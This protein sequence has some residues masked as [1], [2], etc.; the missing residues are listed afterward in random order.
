MNS[1]LKLSYSLLIGAFVAGVVG[2]LFH[3]Y[4]ITFAIILLS[5][6]FLLPKSLS[7]LFRLIAAYGI[8]FVANALIV[9]V[10]S[11]FDLP[12][13]VGWL[14]MSY[15]VVVSSLLFWKRLEL[16]QGQTYFKLSDF[17]IIAAT[18]VVFLLVIVPFRSEKGYPRMLEVLSMAEDNASHYAI[19]HSTTV[20]R[21]YTYF[22][23]APHSGLQ[24]S[25]RIYAQGQHVNMAINNY[26]LT[27]STQPLE[28]PFIIKSF[29]V[30][31]CAFFSLLFMMILLGI[32]RLG[33][34]Y[35]TDK[36][37]AL[38]ILITSPLLIYFVGFGTNIYMFET[39]FHT[40]IMSYSFLLLLLLWIS[41]DK[42]TL[43]W[44]LLGGATALIGLAFSWFFLLPIAGL[45]YLSWLWLQRKKLRPLLKRPAI[46]IPSVLLLGLSLTPFV[47]DRVNHN[48]TNL[49][50]PGGVL[51]V[52][53]PIILFYSGLGII[54]LLSLRRQDFQD[55]SLIKLIILTLGFSLVFTLVIYA[56][57]MITIGETLYYFY[58]TLF[59]YPIIGLLLSSAFIFKYGTLLKPIKQFKKIR[60]TLIAIT[61][62]GL[63]YAL[64]FGFNPAAYTKFY[65]ESRLA[66]HANVG[67]LAPVVEAHKV[68]VTPQ[69]NY[70]FIL[71]DGCNEFRTYITQRWLAA[72]LLTDS[73]DGQR[74]LYEKQL[75][76]E[77]PTDYI[78]NLSTKAKQVDVGY[79]K[80]CL[81]K[82]LPQF[83]PNVHLKQF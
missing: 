76:N 44:R 35:V 21:S 69:E 64:S 8:F 38:S 30:Q 65:L 5:C 32:Q 2:L 75:A 28:Q 6:A 22:M 39:G 9:L 43:A 48:G 1:N 53:L 15:L 62:F 68:I 19:T 13:D 23:D 82:P 16:W 60:F 79:Y 51:I 7:L 58:K 24:P 70:S 42:L 41:L 71:F 80:A 25:L 54:Y 14:L 63:C 27:R 18:V 4:L 3:F 81:D 78:R 66:Y 26:M 10:L 34:R 37:I 29:V 72:I 50:T 31:I 11:K 36:T 40:Q 77:S 49:N 33:Q 12:F 46:V 45:T 67:I 74:V 73:Q 83:P 57:Q 56:Y 55:N 61:T 17:V 52:I 59:L 47:I 20:N